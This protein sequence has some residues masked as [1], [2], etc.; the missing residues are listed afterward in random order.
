MELSEEA[1]QKIHRYLSG[2]STPEERADFEKRMR[3]DDALAHEVATQRRIRNGL[4]AN[5]YKNL[6]RDI[7]AQLQ[8]EGSLAGD[9]G[10]G[11][12]EKGKI[13]PLA[14]E[15]RSTLHWPYVAAA[16]SILVAIGLVWYFNSRPEN[17]P[18]ASDT[19]TT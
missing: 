8:S 12:R 13:V 10:Q 5:E 18:V 17:A 14:P 15:T 2:E 16:A 4:K 11:D 19:P 9:T 7:H 1:F 3:A 6:F